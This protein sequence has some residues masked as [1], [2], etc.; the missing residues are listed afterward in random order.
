MRKPVYPDKESFSGVNYLQQLS[1]AHNWM[2]DET[3][4]MLRHGAIQVDVDCFDLTS[5][6]TEQMD[7]Y[8]L[9]CAEAKKDN[10]S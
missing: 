10:E 6:T 2:Q 3:D 9:E 5:M 8:I 1:N 7:A 4:R